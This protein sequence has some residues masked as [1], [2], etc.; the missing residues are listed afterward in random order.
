MAIPDA[1][2]R[3]FKLLAIPAAV[4]ALAGCSGV[5][6]LPGTGNA[7][8]IEST[9]API[10]LEPKLPT[11]VFTSADGFSADIYLTD[12]TEQDLQNADTLAAASGQI[13]H[14]HLFLVPYPGRTP[15]AESSCTATVRVGIITEGRAGL[16]T[17]GG[18]V[19]PAGRPDDRRFKGRVR[20]ATLRLAGKTSGF[21]D[22][23]EQALLSLDFKARRNDELATRLGLALDRVARSVTPEDHT[24]AGTVR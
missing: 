21:N 15:I 17:G 9:A 18:F 23:I 6:L 3:G 24:L 16:Y 2:A 1:A 20:D 4:S 12:L 8:V 10:A 13:V 19:F 7:L 5:P 11:R 22:A 14:L